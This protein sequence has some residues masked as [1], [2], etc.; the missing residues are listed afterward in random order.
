MFEM[1]AMRAER[2]RQRATE[3]KGYSPSTDESTKSRA[4]A[5][6]QLELLQKERQRLEADLQQQRKMRAAMLALHEPSAMQVERHVQIS[7]T[8]L[9]VRQDATLAQGGLLWSSGLLLARYLRRRGLQQIMESDQKPSVLELGCGVAALPSLLV[10]GDALSVCAT[11]LPEILP[12]TSEN[13]KINAS[14]VDVNPGVIE[15]MAFD[16]SSQVSIGRTFDML[17][18]ADLLYDPQLQEPLVECFQHSVAAG[19]RALVTFQ[20]RDAVVETRFFDALLQRGFQV[21]CPDID[22][23]L[24]E[25]LPPGLKLREVIRCDRSDGDM[26]EQQDGLYL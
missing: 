1:A 9:R 21:C 14:Y 3:D 10:A 17:L 11:D 6:E 19:G 7:D 2:R 5:L 22:G 15:L 23:D 16:W 20:E 12:M 26:Q 13:L 18:A 4:E 24:E 25:D 8:W